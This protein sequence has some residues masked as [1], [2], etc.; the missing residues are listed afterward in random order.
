M[1]SLITP[2][3]PFTSQNTPKNPAAEKSS[4]VDAAG[5]NEKQRASIELLA[6]GKSFKAAASAIE[7]D[8]R[9]LFTWRQDELFQ[10]E[11]HR[12][13]QA[14]WG[15]VADRLRMLVDPSVEVLA[16]HLNDSYDRSR[17]RAAAT[18]LRLA[19]L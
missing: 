19:N 18:I 8:R 4:Q 12:R 14:L 10:S 9:T 1:L 15:D 6:M 3:S 17:F 13:H 5:L 2:E 7:V 11:L 16:E